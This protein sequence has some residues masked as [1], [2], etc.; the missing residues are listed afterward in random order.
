MAAALGLEEMTHRLAGNAI[1]AER[2]GGPLRIVLVGGGPNIATAYEANL[3]LL[4]TSYIDAA[5]YP[6][7]EMLH[8]P[9]AAVTAETLFFLIAPPG[10]ST[11]RAAE[12]ARA[13]GTIG[14]T[15]V[16]LCGDD[17]AGSFDGCH[18]LLLPEVPEVLSPLPYIVP[19]QLFSY[20]LAVGKGYNPD[21][22]H[23]EDERY[24]AARGQYV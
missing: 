18:R 11:D 8:G 17:N 16:V 9:L 13:V 20:F 4:E 19:L 5:A 21:L 1:L 7:E 3:K 12:L 15:P 2:Q 22:L 23:R 24:R 6:L 10:K 14:P